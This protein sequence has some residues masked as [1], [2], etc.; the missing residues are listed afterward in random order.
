MLG[1]AAAAA[2]EEEHLPTAAGIMI[3]IYIYIYNIL[4]QSWEPVL[5][6]K[7]GAGLAVRGDG[8]G[9]REKGGGRAALAFVKGKRGSGCG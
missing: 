1:V 4:Q 7:E 9:G 8:A 2:A 3:Y 6:W 5:G